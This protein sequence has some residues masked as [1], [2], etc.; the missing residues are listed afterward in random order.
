MLTKKQ[1]MVYN[2]LNKF[3]EKNVYVPTVRELCKALNLSSPA[4]VHSYLKI[5]E[6]EGYITRDKNKARSIVTDKVTKT[7]SVPVIGTV[8]AG[9]PI[10][11]YENIEGYLP[12]SQDIAKGRELFILK[13]KGDSMIGK[14]I[15]DGDKLIVKK[16][17][18]ADIGDTV[19]ALIDDSATVKTFKKDNGKVILM[20]ENPDYEP[21]VSDNVVILGVAVGLIREF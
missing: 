14:G 21:I 3:I 1:L 13:V 4:T 12:I 18:D 16:T 20:P 11:A 8:T 7:V 9:L 5:L 10:L 2:E 15:F 19:V 6:Q 17:P